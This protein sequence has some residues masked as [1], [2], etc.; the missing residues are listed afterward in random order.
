MYFRPSQTNNCTSMIVNDSYNIPSSSKKA[1]SKPKSDN[2]LLDNG[3]QT[4]KYSCT[5]HTLS[6]AILTRASFT[7]GT[8][9]AQPT[10]GMKAAL[11]FKGFFHWQG[12]FLD[13]LGFLESKRAFVHQFSCSCCKQRNQSKDD[14]LR[15]TTTPIPTV[16]AV[17]IVRLFKMKSIDVGLKLQWGGSIE[18]KLSFRHL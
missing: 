15:N 3:A 13:R 11:T 14:I 8:N 2:H 5:M 10:L 16:N 17:H 9:Y 6:T 12:T 7:E 4:T 1:F 18:R